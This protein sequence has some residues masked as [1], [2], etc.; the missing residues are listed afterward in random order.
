MKKLSLDLDSLQVDTF[1]VTHEP[2]GEGTVFGQA[3][4]GCPPPCSQLCAYITQASCETQ[5]DCPAC[6]QLCAYIT[7]ESCTHQVQ[8]VPPCSDLCH[9][10]TQ[11]CE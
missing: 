5:R 1:E 9:Y 10:D 11:S 8:C 3:T 4:H 7:Q 2:R 6:S